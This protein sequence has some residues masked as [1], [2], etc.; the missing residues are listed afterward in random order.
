LLALLA[1]GHS[2]RGIARHLGWGFRTVHRYARAATWQE[3]VDGKWQRPR[4]SK[5]DAFPN[6]PTKPGGASNNPVEGWKRA[7]KAAVPS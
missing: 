5:L 1:Q 4:P 2:L 6:S 3:L 7:L